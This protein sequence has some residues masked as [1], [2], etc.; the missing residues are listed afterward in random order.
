M[1]V[2]RVKE[3]TRV[4]DFNPKRKYLIFENI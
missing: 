3:C 2:Q 1:E 4:D